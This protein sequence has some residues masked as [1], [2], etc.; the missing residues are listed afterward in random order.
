[1]ARPKPSASAGSDV[2]DRF[3]SGSSHNCTI[4]SGGRQVKSNTVARIISKPIQKLGTAIKIVIVTRDI[5]SKSE[6]RHMALN[7]PMG[8]PIS[9]EKKT[10]MSAICAVM[11]PRR[12]INSLIGSFVQNEEPSSPL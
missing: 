9:Q 6:L 2:I 4:V 3:F 10:A 1:A 11:G 7:K 5:W 12:R 8:T